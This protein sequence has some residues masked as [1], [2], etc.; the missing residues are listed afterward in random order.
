MVISKRSAT[1][2]I[3]AGAMDDELLQHLIDA[4]VPTFSMS[5]GLTLGDFGW[6]SP[7]FNKMGRE[8]ISLIQTFV[9]WGVE[10]IISD[11]DTVWLRDPTEFA[12]QYPDV[13]V[14]SSSDHLSAT[15]TDGGLE[16][17]GGVY[18][19]ANIGI[20]LF[21]PKAVDLVDEWV[22]ILDRDASV[23]DQNA[24]NDLIKR[25]LKHPPPGERVFL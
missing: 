13:D 15:S 8:K 25:G 18:S 3:F 17:E 22:D 4:K 11:V 2:P 6:G 7:T 16:N 5:S 9:H 23:W 10:V 24:F 20:M 12:L 19:A 14:L 21:R 1:D